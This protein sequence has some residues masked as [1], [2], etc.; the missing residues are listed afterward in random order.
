MCSS[1]GRM[2]ARSR[3]RPIRQ[4]MTQ[5]TMLES[6]RLFAAQR[7]RLAN[8]ERQQAIADKQALVQWLERGEE[9]LFEASVYATV[10]APTLPALDER[11]RRVEDAFSRSQMQTRRVLLQPLGALESTLPRGTDPP[12]RVLSRE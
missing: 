9:R 12:G 1:T 5:L 8:A 6:S 10:Q 7:G 2:R 4:Y 11:T 3:S